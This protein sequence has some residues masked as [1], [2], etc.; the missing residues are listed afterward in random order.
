MIEKSLHFSY[1]KVTYDARSAAP[2]FDVTEGERRRLMHWISVWWRQPDHYDWLSDY[3]AARRLQPFARSLLVVILTTL[4]AATMLMLS[5]PSGPQTSAQRAATVAIIVSFGGIA[6]IY[7]LRWPTRVQSQILSVAGTLSIAAACVIEKD[8]RSGL[9]GCAAFGG[10]A[11]YVAFFHSARLLVFTVGT[12]LSTAAL[13]AARVAIDGDASM[14]AAKWLVLSAGILAVPFCGQV[15]V[16]WLSVDA[17]KS[18]TDPLTGLRNRRGFYK[19]APRLL[20]L[21]EGPRCLSVL[22][23]DLDNFKRINDTYGHATGDRILVAVADNL[24]RIRDGKTVIARVGGEEFLVAESIGMQEALQTA[25]AM[26]LA[27]TATPWQ[28]TASL[29]V[30]SISLSTRIDSHHRQIVE[31]LVEAADS[32]MYEAKRAGGNQVRSS[33]QQWIS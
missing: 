28:V 32:A 18:S 12:A 15:L 27:I 25:E 20:S 1:W 14:A 11:G 10:L 31:S 13:C 29:G 16:H 5:S 23:I 7:L 26:R 17:L 2:L 21:G 9:L 19:A 22:M 3:L 6:L 4:V 30:S 24:R 33:D 8:P